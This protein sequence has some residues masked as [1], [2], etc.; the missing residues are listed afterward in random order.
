MPVTRILDPDDQALDISHSTDQASAAAIA[1]SQNEEGAGESEGE[2]E[3]GE[4]GEDEQDPQE[5]GSDGET[6]ESCEDVEEHMTDEQFDASLLEIEYKDHSDDVL[7]ILHDMSM[8]TDENKFWHYF[9]QLPKTAHRCALEQ[10][11]RLMVYN[12]VCGSGYITGD[13]DICQGVERTVKQIF[14]ICMTTEARINLLFNGLPSFV[15]FG[16]EFLHNERA[17]CISKSPE[18][19]HLSMERDHFQRQSE[20]LNV[21]SIT[22]TAQVQR[23][24]NMLT[25]MGEAA[26]AV[27]LEQQMLAPRACPAAE[28]T[29]TAHAEASQALQRLDIECE[30]KRHELKTYNNELILAQAK[31]VLDTEE[32]RSALDDARISTDQQLAAMEREIEVAREQCK[33]HQRSVDL[34]LQ[35]SRTHVE[36]QLASLAE[37]TKNALVN[38]NAVV[39]RCDGDLK[40]LEREENAHIV[41]MTAAHDKIVLENEVIAEKNRALQETLSTANSRMMTQSKERERLF[42]QEKK[43]KV[44]QLENSIRAKSASNTVLTESNRE[45]ADTVKVLTKSLQEHREHKAIEQKK[46]DL[47]VTRNKALQQQNQKS[48]DHVITLGEQHSAMKRDSMRLITESLDHSKALEQQVRTAVQRNVLL[49]TEHGDMTRQSQ[50]DRLELHTLHKSFEAL[51]KRLGMAEE[52]LRRSEQKSAGLHAN[53]T[54]LRGVASLILGMD[55]VP[56]AAAAAPESTGATAALHSESAAKGQF[57]TRTL[58]LIETVIARREAEGA[59]PTSALVTAGAPEVVP[60]SEAS[61]KASPFVDFSDL[62]AQ[63]DHFLRTPDA[64]KS[65]PVLLAD[66][67]HAQHPKHAHENGTNPSVSGQASALMTADAKRLSEMEALGMCKETRVVGEFIDCTDGYILSSISIFEMLKTSQKKH[68]SVEALPVKISSQTVRRK[69]LR[70]IAIMPCNEQ[71]RIALNIACSLQP[72]KKEM[73]N[74]LQSHEQQASVM[75]YLLMRQVLPPC[76]TWTED[77]CSE[78]WEH[79]RITTGAMLSTP[80]REELKH[81]LRERNAQSS[82][83]LLSNA[84]YRGIPEDRAYTIQSIWSKREVIANMLA[85]G[86]VPDRHGLTSFEYLEDVLDEVCPHGKAPVVCM[87]PVKILRMSPNST[88]A[89]QLYCAGATLVRMLRE[90]EEPNDDMRHFVNEVKTHCLSFVQILPTTSQHFDAICDAFVNGRGLDVSQSLLHF[91]IQSDQTTRKQCMRPACTKQVKVWCGGCNRMLYCSRACREL[92]GEA[93]LGNCHVHHVRAIIRNGM[94]AKGVQDMIQAIFGGCCS[95]TTMVADLG[96]L[97]IACMVKAEHERIKRISTRN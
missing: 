38:F 25:G 24:N 94:P 42:M 37:D 27:A 28:T 67:L 5:V 85:A 14:L 8:V 55:E 90:L 31:C 20:Y 47:V 36:A 44:Q 95:N 41:Q 9:R 52:A 39:A 34:E 51:A 60:D 13:N 84:L 46:M 18:F 12:C 87:S 1:D 43:H 32:L 30:N 75:M 10:S 68:L 22:L 80:A 73:L 89:T 15:A 76:P 29:Y 40:T 92:D 17:D 26:K 3:G 63:L 83:V 59:G 72:H 61:S 64:A 4:E 57:V 56:E 23:L 48:A 54:K 45:Q 16:Y 74:I 69:I 6:E 66:S 96:C 77:L 2:S 70:D 35:Q 58:E 11:A 50:A 71:F 65:A 81:A 49:Q 86:P 88:L 7:R 53:L 78:H 82:F 91:Y 93:H 21:A 62:E 33:A 19:M 79:V 97:C